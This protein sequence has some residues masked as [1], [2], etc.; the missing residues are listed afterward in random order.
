MWVRYRVISWPRLGN[1]YIYIFITRNQIKTNNISSSVHKKQTICTI[2]WWRMRLTRKFWV[3]LCDNPTLG[4]KSICQR[5]DKFFW[6]PSPKQWICITP[7]IKKCP[8][9][10]RVLDVRHPALRHPAL[11]NPA[12]RRGS[13]RHCST[14]GKLY[15]RYNERGCKY[16]LILSM[17]TPFYDNRST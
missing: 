15:L 2:V 6:S 16:R 14:P 5:Y 8:T 13:N 10:I 11:R 9:F 17:R 7:Q 4:Q 3:L 12:L 1:T